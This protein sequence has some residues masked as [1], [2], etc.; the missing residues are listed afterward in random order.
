MM[1]GDD[2][3]HLALLKKSLSTSGRKGE[4]LDKLQQDFVVL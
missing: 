3:A 2:F 1:F 4:Q